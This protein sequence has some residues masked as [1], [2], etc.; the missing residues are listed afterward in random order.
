MAKTIV[1]QKIWK[2][3]HLIYALLALL[4]TVAFWRGAWM[5]LDN[6]PILSDPIICAGFGLV[7]LLITGLLLKEVMI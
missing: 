3:H 5:I 4:G 2:K 7:L 6:T 1:P